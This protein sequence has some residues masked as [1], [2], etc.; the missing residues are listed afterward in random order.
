MRCHCISIYRESKQLNL[1]NY[2]ASKLL[3]NI[4]CCP[5]KQLTVKCSSV[6]IHILLSG[7][8]W[9]GYSISKHLE[10]WC[11]VLH[12]VIITFITNLFFLSFY[13]YIIK[14]LSY[15]MCFY[16]KFIYLVRSPTKGI[17]LRLIQIRILITWKRNCIIRYNNRRQFY[18][19]TIKYRCSHSKEYI[20]LFTEKINYLFYI[21]S[22]TFNQLYVWR[23][24]LVKK[25]V[26]TV[27]L[28]YNINIGLHIIT[29]GYYII[30][31]ICYSK[32]FIKYKPSQNSNISFLF[33][34]Y[35]LIYCFISFRN[36]YRYVFLFKFNGIC[37]LRQQMCLIKEKHTGSI[38]NQLKEL[39]NKSCGTM[40]VSL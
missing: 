21:H 24:L 6:E 27:T 19:S 34:Y 33:L 37:V 5:Q 8:S 40:P 22:L 16:I 14:N 20:Y 39:I 36:S 11:M 4:S 23:K 18:G 9:C 10:I 17:S 35:F 1:V 31:Q 15:S 38:S 12:I 13:I 30:H 3:I 26:L 7:H 28:T 2:T 32:Y 29:W 25:H